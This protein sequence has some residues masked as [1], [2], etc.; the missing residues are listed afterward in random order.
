MRSTLR[1][2]HTCSHN[3]ILV[4]PNQKTA[5][6]VQS[7][8]RYSRVDEYRLDAA[9]EH[10]A[11][12]EVEYTSMTKVTQRSSLKGRHVPKPTKFWPVCASIV[13]SQEIKDY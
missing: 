10:T 8:G 13:C 3:F 12:L 4:T 6:R 9:T 5:E 7:S 2:S 11:L 1:H